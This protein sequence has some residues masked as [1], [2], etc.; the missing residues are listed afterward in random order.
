MFGVEAAQLGDHLVSEAG[1]EVVLLGVTAEIGEGQNHE[2]NFAT[3]ELARLKPSK[4]AERGRAENSNREE[5]EDD[6]Q[7]LSQPGPDC[8]NVADP[9]TSRGTLRDAGL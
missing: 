8:R 4:N 9:G 5:R 6:N 7:E 3:Q 1:A 2:A